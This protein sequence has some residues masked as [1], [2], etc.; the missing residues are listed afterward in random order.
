M[1]GERPRVFIALPLSDDQ[2]KPL[3]G[4]EVIRRKA[5]GPVSTDELLEMLSDADGHLGS[6]QVKIPNDVIDSAR[7]LRVIS[8]FGV[9]FDN[10]DLNH[11][12]SRGIDVCNTPGV[13][14][15]AVADLTL[16]L[17][18]Q[19][20]RG[21]AGAQA[22]VREGRWVRGMAPPP[23][24]T[25]LKGKT[26]S[27][28]GMGRIG[29]EV[30]SRAQAFGMRVL[31]YDLRG[32]CEAPPGAECA[33][34]FDE[35]LREADFVSIH[36][37]L[38]P[39]SMHLIDKTALSMMKPSAYL[40]NTARGPIVDQAALYEALKGERIAGAALDVLEAEPPDADEP[41]LALPNVIVT[42]HIGSATRETR[43]AMARLAVQNLADC[44]EGRPCANIV[45]R[46]P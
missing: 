14:S 8:N 6:A 7:R 17:M 16:G 20:A 1:A 4:F 18:L 9:G 35:A 22:M 33:A 46:A 37:N 5:A 2:L 15:D 29:L 30:A 28:I 23:L 24:G 36:T 38:T 13:L 34:G 32:D 42:P 27:I 10:V 41:L 40:L 11:A 31:F 39:E 19:L 44:I 25:D 21:L 12:R 3:A 26:L 43:D 45:N